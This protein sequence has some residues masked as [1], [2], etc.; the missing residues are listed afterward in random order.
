[1]LSIN[2]KWQLAISNNILFLDMNTE[3]KEYKCVLV[4]KIMIEN[5]SSVTQVKRP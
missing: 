5:I 4:F 2:Q 1:M 3:I